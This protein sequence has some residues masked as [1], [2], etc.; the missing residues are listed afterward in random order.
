MPYATYIKLYK[1]GKPVGRAYRSE[2]GKTK[3]EAIAAE[4]KRSKEWNAWSAKQKGQ[5]FKFRVKLVK[6]AK[7]KR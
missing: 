6:V 7:V 1:D 4:N 5:P 3:K 2:T